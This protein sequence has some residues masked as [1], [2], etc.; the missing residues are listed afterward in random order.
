[1][2]LFT[3]GKKWKS[4]EAPVRQEMGITPDVVRLA[5][6]AVCRMMSLFLDSRHGHA[7][8]NH[9]TRFEVI[10]ARVNMVGHENKLD[11]IS[12]F[13]FVKKGT[14]SRSIP[15]GSSLPVSHA[16]ALDHLHSAAFVTSPRLTGLL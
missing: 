3:Q 16:L 15:N 1:M 11:R 14:E 7:S 4:L 9:G 12:A 6:L 13:R 8:V 5:R 10:H 2:A